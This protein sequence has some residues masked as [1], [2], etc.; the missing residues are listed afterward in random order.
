MLDRQSSGTPIAINGSTGE[1]L[2]PDPSEEIQADIQSRRTEWLAGR[3]EAAQT[4]QQQA[5][6]KDRH[7]V[8][9]FANIGGIKVRGAVQMVLKELAY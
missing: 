7:R 6:T 4:S 8:E 9:V 2:P 1:V 3:G 5:M